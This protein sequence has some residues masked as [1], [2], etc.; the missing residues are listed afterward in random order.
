MQRDAL[1]R[2]SKAELIELVLRLQRPE[3]TSRTSSKPPS[4]DR[5]E[6]R[7]RAKPGGAKPGHEGH[8]RPLSD[9]VS[10]RVAHRPR[11]ARAA[12]WRWRPICRPKTAGRPR[13][14]RAARGQAA[15]RAPPSRWRCA[16]PDCGTRVVAPVPAQRHAVRPAPAR[17]GHLPQDLPGAVLRAAAG[18][19]RRPVRAAPQPGRAD[20]PAPPRPGS[21]PGRA[22]GGRR[23]AAPGRGGRLG[24]DRRP[25]RGLHR[26]PLGV[27]LPGGRG[28]P[29]R[30]D[31]R[32]LGG[33][34]HDGRA[35][36]R[37]LALGPLRGAAGPR[38][39]PADL[40]GASGARRGVR[41]RGQRRPGAVPAQALAAT[42]PS[43]WPTPPQALPPPPWR[44]SGGRSNAG[45]PRSWQPPAA[46]T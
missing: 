46:A 29:R 8:S 43:T 9:D 18:R 31:P 37:G 20:E 17:G 32:R 1:E 45:W 26:L 38:L 28:A 19:A 27:P 40:P 4:T 34:R 10:E 7:E 41:G 5:K 30:A 12:G 24:R 22:R 44:P 16:A 23:G 14:H 21:V 6:R 15:G 2:L 25:D 39:G 36:P 13:A 33:A 35:P 42:Q 3:K 11:P